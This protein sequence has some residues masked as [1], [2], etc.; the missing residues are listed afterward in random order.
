MN[1][2]MISVQFPTAL[3]VYLYTLLMPYLLM[4]FTPCINFMTS[5]LIEVGVV[6]TTW[7]LTCLSKR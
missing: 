1:R 3:C 4:R 5:H 2:N 7:P 6:K